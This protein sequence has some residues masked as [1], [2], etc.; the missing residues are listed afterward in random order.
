MFVVYQSA[1]PNE[2]L[3][4]VLGE[5]ASREFSVTALVGG[6]LRALYNEDEQPSSPSLNELLRALEDARSNRFAADEPRVTEE[7]S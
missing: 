6:K 5:L 3:D 1:T 2:A 4:Q 7:G